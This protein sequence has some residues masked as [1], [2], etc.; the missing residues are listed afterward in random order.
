M[1]TP[2]PVLV[3]ALR[4]DFF[5]MFERSY[6]R[7]EA[8][9]PG[10]GAAVYRS[11]AAL[12]AWLCG[13]RWAQDSLFAREAPLVRRFLAEAKIAAGR[14]DEVLRG[15]LALN[16]LSAA[17]R[18]VL[19]LDPTGLLAQLVSVAGRANLESALAH[20]RGVVLA[21]SRTPFGALLPAWLAQQGIAIAQVDE[22]PGGGDA[23]LR[24]LRSGGIALVAAEGRAGSARAAFRFLGRRR[25]IGTGFAELAADTGAVLLPVSV[26]AA[27]SGE[28][29]IFI[30][31]PLAAA[32]NSE[33]LPALVDAYAQHLRELWSSCPENVGWPQLELYLRLPAQPA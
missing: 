1:S 29:T 20:G 3:A 27:P 22:R 17:W 18:G 25:T 21:Q 19:A 23:A 2:A 12:L 10:A 33:R 30:D 5:R 9:K 11:S 15:N 13:E 4:A 32:A 26:R 16:S 6:A 28:L 24:R 31:P 7:M 14:E 8:G